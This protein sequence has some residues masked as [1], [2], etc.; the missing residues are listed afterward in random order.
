MCWLQALNDS[1]YRKKGLFKTPVLNSLYIR[2]LILTCCMIRQKKAKDS[3]VVGKL[4]EK[5]KLMYRKL[6]I[7]RADLN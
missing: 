5:C 1:N 3:G 6:E 2:A 7:L 4:D